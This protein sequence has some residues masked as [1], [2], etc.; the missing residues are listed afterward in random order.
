[1]KNPVHDDRQFVQAVTKPFED[2]KR[3][4]VSIL[5]DGL[6]RQCNSDLNFRW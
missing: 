2:L 6:L 4:D 1:M 5:V 3:A